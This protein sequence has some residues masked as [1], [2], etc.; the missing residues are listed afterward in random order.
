MYL[1]QESR[2]AYVMLLMAI[3]W[4]TEAVPLAITSLIP[5]MLFPLLGVL[6]TGDVCMVY[7]KETNML[8]VAGLIV[9]IAIEYCNLHKRIA[10]RVLLLVGTSPRM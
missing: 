2:C 3:F 1:F 8:M 6:S 9:A 10:L 4:M 5:V 7:L